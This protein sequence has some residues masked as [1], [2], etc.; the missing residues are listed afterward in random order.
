MMH[1]TMNKKL[2]KSCFCYS[3]YRHR[4]R[5]L[6]RASSC[7]LRALNVPGNVER[8]A[9]NSRHLAIAYRR[10]TKRYTKLLQGRGSILLLRHKDL[11][12]LHNFAH[13]RSIN[14][15]GAVHSSSSQLNFGVAGSNPTPG[16][17]K[18]PTSSVQHVGTE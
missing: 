16:I 8:N 17:S 4:T 7:A 6:N 9:R 15:Q 5:L 14:A 18:S 10:G 2:I 1:G 3:T 12:K 13:L 11:T